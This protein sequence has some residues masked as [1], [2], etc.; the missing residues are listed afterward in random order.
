MT[1]IETLKFPVLHHP[2][3]HI[4][5][6][7]TCLKDHL[8]LL[9]YFI[10]KTSINI[11]HLAKYRQWLEKRGIECETEYGWATPEVFDKRSIEDYIQDWI[12]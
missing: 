6:C 8:Y 1:Q 5:N 10:Q 11:D 4:H 3:C 9:N 12:G 7:D 2:Y